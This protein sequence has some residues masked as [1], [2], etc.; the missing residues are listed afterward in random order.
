MRKSVML[1]CLLLA[2]CASHPKSDTPNIAGSDSDFPRLSEEFLVGY[3][4]WRPQVG[5]SLGLH[6]FDGKV[7]DLDRPSWTAE[8]AR[9]KRFDSQLAKFSTSSLS[10]GASYDYRI[11]Q[12]GIKREIF[13]F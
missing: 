10:S 12:A 7:T 11:L 5:T 8:L 2:G 4:A 13:R 9:L 3:L 6:E 1:L